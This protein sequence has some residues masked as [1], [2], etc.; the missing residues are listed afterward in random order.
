ML[1][2][3]LLVPKISELSPEEMKG[4]TPK[5]IAEINERIKN[6]SR[7]LKIETYAKENKKMADSRY[8]EGR[9]NEQMAA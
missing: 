3:N 6:A 4:K 8:T 1:N 2:E 7:G 9:D 5:E